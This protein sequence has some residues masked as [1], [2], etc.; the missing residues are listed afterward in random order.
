MN[1]FLYSFNIFR[2]CGLLFEKSSNI[3]VNS[4]NSAKSKS[5]QVQDFFKRNSNPSIN[6]FNI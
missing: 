5:V 4:F 3:S 6:N 1:F 2:S